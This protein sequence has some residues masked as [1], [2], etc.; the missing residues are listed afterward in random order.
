MVS[1]FTYGCLFMNPRILDHFFWIGFTM[2]I[3][4]WTY[5]ILNFA[6]NG[7]LVFNSGLVLI[8]FILGGIVRTGF[9]ILEE[10][11]KFN[12]L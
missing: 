11:H 6:F 4:A 10:I 12:E 5:M 9:S 3:S 1:W 2:L 7:A 8:A